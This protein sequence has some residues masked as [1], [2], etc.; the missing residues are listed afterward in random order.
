[1]T[2]DEARHLAEVLNAWADGATMQ[3]RYK[4]TKVWRDCVLPACWE[5]DLIDPDKCEYRIK[6]EPREFWLNPS[7][8][9][10]V[11]VE[12]ADQ[13]SMGPADK[14]ILVREVIDE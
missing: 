3:W 11:P 13:T 4:A 12:E 10:F 14:V 2:K 5:A 9:Q 1:M 8:R 7:A 6:P